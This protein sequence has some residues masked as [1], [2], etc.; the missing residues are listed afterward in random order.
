MHADCIIHPVRFIVLLAS[1]LFV[2]GYDGTQIREFLL[3]VATVIVVASR[4]VRPRHA[5]VDVKEQSKRDESGREHR[6]SIG[7]DSS[8]QFAD[9][10]NAIERNQEAN[11]FV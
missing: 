3:G 5:R 2:S 1:Y 11:Q 8:E 10:P 6:L 4:I 9:S 7:D